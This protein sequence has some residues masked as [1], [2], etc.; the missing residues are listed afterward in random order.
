MSN[1]FAIAAACTLALAAMTTPSLAEAPAPGSDPLEW[2]LLSGGE[3]VPQPPGSPIAACCTPEGCVIC[4]ADWSDCEFD[5]PY[6]RPGGQRPN[7]SGADQLAPP[8]TNGTT[9][10]FAP[11]QLQL[12]AQ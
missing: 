3:S 2:C 12:R 7:H 5:P 4:D 1:A 9:G 11:L 8:S 10:Q 6:S